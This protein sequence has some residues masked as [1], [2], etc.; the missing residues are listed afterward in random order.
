MKYVTNYWVFSFNF[1]FLCVLF[2]L[3]EKSAIPEEEEEE[4]LPTQETTKNP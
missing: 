2:L 1:K 3:G 4:P